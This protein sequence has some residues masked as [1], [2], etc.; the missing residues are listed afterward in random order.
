MKKICGVFLKKILDDK[1][2]IEKAKELITCLAVDD[3][4]FKAVAQEFGRTGAVGEFIDSLER[5]L[6]DQERKKKKKT[7]PPPPPPPQ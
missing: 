4:H 5:V 3:V 1:F 2:G 6:I 7:S